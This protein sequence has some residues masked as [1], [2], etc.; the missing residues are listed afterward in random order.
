MA[1][2]GAAVLCGGKSRRMGR[3]K[4]LLPLGDTTFLAHALETV[5]DFPEVLLS[6][7]QEGDYSDFGVPVVADGWPD[8]GPLGGICSV[9][10]ACR[11]EAMLCLS[12]DMPQ[13]TGEFCHYLCGLLDGYDAVVP[14]TADG[15]V[16]PLCAVYHC[17]ALP[18]LQE[19]LKRGDLRLQSALS[20]LQVLYVDV[21]ETTFTDKLLRNIN[22]PQEYAAL[23]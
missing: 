5:R 18:T 7:A 16:H 8:T 2:I 14:T 17:R 13:V 19:H 6:A 21:K 11:S 1:A 20:D 23:T 12:C 3:D 9:L 4:A 15:R 22:T 10:T